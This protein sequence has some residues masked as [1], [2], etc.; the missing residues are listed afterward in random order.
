VTLNALMALSMMPPPPKG[1]LFFMEVPTERQLH[2][3]Q[4]CGLLKAKEEEEGDR[5]GQGEEG[6]GERQGEGEAPPIIGPEPC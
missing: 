6:E 2:F 4:K 1:V 3:L 5:A